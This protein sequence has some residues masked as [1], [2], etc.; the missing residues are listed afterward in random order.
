MIRGIENP[1]TYRDE[2]IEVSTRY[3]TEVEDAVYITIRDT[4]PYD[5]SVSEAVAQIKL[6]QVMGLI[7][8]IREAATRAELG[9]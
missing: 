2:G 1:V 5:D 9:T 4:D 6:G 8:A 7:E 3:T